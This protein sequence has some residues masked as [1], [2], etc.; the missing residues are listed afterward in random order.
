MTCPE[1]SCPIKLAPAYCLGPLGLSSRPVGSKWFWSGAFQDGSGISRDSKSPCN[2]TCLYRGQ[3]R[4]LVGDGFDFF[5]FFLRSL[6]NKI[7]ADDLQL[8]SWLG[9]FILACKRKILWL[10]ICDKTG[11]GAQERVEQQQPLKEGLGFCAS[12]EAIEI[13]VLW[14]L[15]VSLIE[16]ILQEFN[17]E[18]RFLKYVLW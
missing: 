14:K 3:S 13:S 18:L 17:S 12:K 11:C 10:W 8:M 9:H 16:L 15:N 5:F 4:I 7:P 6:Q 2:P 1:T